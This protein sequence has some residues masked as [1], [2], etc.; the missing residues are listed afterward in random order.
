MKRLIAPLMAA[1]LL[2]AGLATAAPQPASPERESTP[3]RQG[4]GQHSD[5]QSRTG[6]GRQDTGK[7]PSKSTSATHSRQSDSQHAERRSQ[8]PKKGDKLAPGQRGELVKNYRK[9]GLKKPP[10]GHQ[11]RKVDNRYVLIAV[12][13]GIVASVVAN[14][15]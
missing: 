1:S 9:Q 6:Q 13:T 14:G 2:A 3:S 10:R 12:A 11:W 8:A 5:D 15:R 4:D 7:A